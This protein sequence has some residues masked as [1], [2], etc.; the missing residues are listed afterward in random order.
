M[1]IFALIDTAVAFQ[2]V[3]R[4]ES[5]WKRI[6][7]KKAREDEHYNHIREEGLKG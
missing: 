3:H 7:D 4:E 1:G 6:E 5:R 2:A